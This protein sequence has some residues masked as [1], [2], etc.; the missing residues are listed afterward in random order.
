VPQVTL[1][2]G[3]RIFRHSAAGVIQIQPHTR[4]GT[5]FDT[6]VTGI[7]SASCAGQGETPLLQRTRLALLAAASQPGHDDA[8][9]G[10]GLPIVPLA[11][12]SISGGDLNTVIA[13]PY[14][15]LRIGF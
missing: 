4:S 1:A 14:G 3:I 13:P 12:A 8:R 9:A 11:S 2:V 10:S 5:K 6:G 15:D 7:R